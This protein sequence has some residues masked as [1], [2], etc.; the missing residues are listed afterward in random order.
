MAT[1]NQGNAKSQMLVTAAKTMAMILFAKAHNFDH[2][3]S[4]TLQQLVTDQHPKIRRTVQHQDFMSVLELWSCETVYLVKLESARIRLA[5]PTLHG[6][7]Q[8]NS[9]GCWFNPTPHCIKHISRHN[10]IIWQ[11]VE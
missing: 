2:E 4:V 8:S 9:L 11:C 5:Y 1:L 6:R 7:R 3:L 10:F